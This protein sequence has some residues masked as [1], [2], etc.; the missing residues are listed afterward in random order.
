M[1]LTKHVQAAVAYASSIDHPLVKDCHD[2][3]IR[4]QIWSRHDHT[5]PTALPVLE[6]AHKVGEK[7]GN[8]TWK[9]LGSFYHPKV[10]WWRGFGVYIGSANLT[11]AAWSSN[12][13][14]GIFV[15]ETQLDAE[16][17]RDQLEDFFADIDE[18]SHQITPQILDDARALLE[19]E[20][21]IDALRKR[22]HQ[23][24]L[25]SPHSKAFTQES[26]A[27]VNRVPARDRRKDA[28]LKEWNETLG[29]L[30]IVQARLS[31]PRNRPR[32]VPADASPGI[33]TDQF[34]HAFYYKKVRDGISHPVEKWHAENRT[35]PE[36][37]LRAA[38]GWWRDTPEP[39]DQEDRVF[40]QWAPLHR[41]LLTPD[42]LQRMTSDEFAQVV[43]CVHAFRNYAK[44]R[45]AD[46]TGQ[47]TDPEGSLID[48]K[49]VAY[50]R[51]VYFGSNALGWHPPRLLQYLLFDGPAAEAPLRLFNCLDSPYKVPG[52]DLS[53]LGE[54]IGCGLP[55][56]FPP[57]N[58][59]T[60]KAL[61]ALGWDV[62]VR[63]P[64][65][66]GD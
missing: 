37:A 19:Y 27:T 16:G 46:D 43:S 44:Y 56:V 8:I 25:S 58:D 54:L 2:R 33:H 39:P 47:E 11:K 62:V 23:T 34:L 63:N 17:V 1:E 57:R 6:W 64:N 52:L 55:N 45:D 13:E 38:I 35:N 50:G 3:R 66:E 29:Y 60:N 36:A 4:C 15:T 28:F 24:L 12:C 49:S 40:E 14:A 41:V 10:I 30:R 21:E 65:R 18:Q 61:R 20:T 51:E 26:L 22:M 7:N 48:T 9:L 32:W 31:E 42:R 59:R 53:S 5:L